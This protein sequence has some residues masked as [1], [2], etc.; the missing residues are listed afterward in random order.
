MAAIQRRKTSAA[1]RNPAGLLVPVLL[2]A[3]GVVLAR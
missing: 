2:V 1:R 3:A